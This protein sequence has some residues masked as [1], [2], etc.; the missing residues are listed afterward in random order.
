ME[1]LS[2]RDALFLAKSLHL[3]SYSLLGDSQ[4]AI[5]AVIDE[6]EVTSQ[7]CIPIILEI[8]HLLLSSSHLGIFWVKRCDNIVAHE[9]AFL[10][11]TTVGC[12]KSWDTTPD[13]LLSI[14]AG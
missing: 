5:L 4:N 11:K 2:L 1:L 6:A 8:K 14:R 13:E 9:L 3:H 7:L 10:A 12:N